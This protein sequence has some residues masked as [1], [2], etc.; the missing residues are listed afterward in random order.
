MGSVNFGG[1]L[2]L[3]MLLDIDYFKWINDM[4]GY[5]V[6]DFVLKIFVE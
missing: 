6:G 5:E 3:V 2:V 1:V 4:Y